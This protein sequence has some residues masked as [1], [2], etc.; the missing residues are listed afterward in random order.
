MLFSHI[1]LQTNAQL[2][3]F[4]AVQA[5][6]QRLLCERSHQPSEQYVLSGLIPLFSPSLFPRGVFLLPLRQETQETVRNAKVPPKGGQRHAKG[7][8]KEAPA[9]PRG[10]QGGLKGGQGEADT[11]KHEG[12]M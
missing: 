1:V 10:R 3:V 5:I 6:T 4:D 11:G 9:W 7:R 8:Q 2:R 12:D